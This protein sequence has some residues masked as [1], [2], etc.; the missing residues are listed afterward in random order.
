MRYNFL[1]QME[2]TRLQPAHFF[3]KSKRQD[4]L[5]GQLEP[6]GDQVLDS[7]PKLLF[8]RGNMYQAE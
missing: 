5:P 7:G 1:G 3:V 8:R 2:G 4:N 6:S